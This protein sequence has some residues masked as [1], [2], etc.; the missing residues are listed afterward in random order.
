MNH[1]S[2]LILLGVFIIFQFPSIFYT[3]TYSRLHWRAVYE[4]TIIY[5]QSSVINFTFNTVVH[6]QW[7]TSHYCPIRHTLQFM[8]NILNHRKYIPRTFCT[9]FISKLSNSVFNKQD[10]LIYVCSC[11]SESS[12]QCYGIIT[13]IVY[14]NLNLYPQWKRGTARRPSRVVRILAMTLTERKINAKVLPLYQSAA[15]DRPPRPL[16]VIKHPR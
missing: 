3:L 10:Y 7:V 12:G 11:M 14:T 2:N 5:H 9:K 1:I 4:N 6:N 8:T 15:G 13:M 16:R